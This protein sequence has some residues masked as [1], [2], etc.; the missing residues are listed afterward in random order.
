M[1]C[2]GEWQRRGGRLGGGGEKIAWE[3]PPRNLLNGFY[4]TFVGAPDLGSVERGRPPFFRFVPIS[5]I[6]SDFCSDLRS[7]IVFG[8]CSD[9]WFLPI[10]FL[11]NEKTMPLE[12]CATPA[13]FVIVVLSRGLSSKALVLLVRTQ[14]RHFRPLSSNKPLFWQGDKGTVCQRYR[15]FFFFPR[16]VSRTNQRN[17]LLPTPFASPRIR[18]PCTHFGHALLISLG[19]FEHRPDQS[20]L[21]RR[22]PRCNVVLEGAISDEISTPKVMW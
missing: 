10:G 20:R 21:T 4:G 5:P 22:S 8:I 13:I 2:F 9:F 18:L 11:G 6:C 3:P 17:P 14:I 15:F 19:T 12:N 16:F 1:A 7:L